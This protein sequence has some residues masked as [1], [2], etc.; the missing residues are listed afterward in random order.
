VD[1][2]R[3]GAG[4]F[5]GTTLLV[6][7][8]A[9]AAVPHVVQPGETLSGIAAANGLAT[10]SVAAFNGLSVDT[11]VI[12]GQTLQIPDAT[13]APATSTPAAPATPAPAAEATTTTTPMAPAGLDPAAAES[14]AA[15]AEAARTQFGVE[16][17]SAGPLSGYRTYEQQAALYDQYLAGTGAPANPPG[18]SSHELGVAVDLATPEMRSVVDQIGGAYGWSG[19]IPSEWWHVSWGGY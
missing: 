15:M 3:V 18:T 7:S 1:K 11:Y 13:E 6:T 9:G 5:L 2:R 19:T 10:D 12:S 4:V 17:Q 14:W 16:L 8:P